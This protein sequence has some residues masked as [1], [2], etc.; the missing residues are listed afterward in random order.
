MSDDCY[1]YDA[2]CVVESSSGRETI[3]RPHVVSDGDDVLQSN[4]H[5]PLLIIFDHA[6]ISARIISEDSVAVGMLPRS[7]VVVIV[8]PNAVGMGTQEARMARALELLRSPPRASDSREHLIQNLHA[9]SLDL[10]SVF[11]RA[12]A[13]KKNMQKKDEDEEEEDTIIL[14]DDIRAGMPGHHAPPPFSP[15]RIRYTLVREGDLLHLVYATLSR[16]QLTPSYSNL[17][18]IIDEA[19]VGPLLNPDL[20][21]PPTV[22]TDE[23][24]E[25]LIQPFSGGGHAKEHAIEINEEEEDEDEDEDEEV[26]EVKADKPQ[27]VAAARRQRKRASHAQRV[28]SPLLVSDGTRVTEMELST[29]DETGFFYESVLDWH[30][31]R[32]FARQNEPEFHRRNREVYVCGT[33]LAAVLMT[34]VANHPNYTADQVIAHRFSDKADMNLKDYYTTKDPATGKLKSLLLDRNFLFFPVNHRNRHWVLY[35]AWRPFS[36]E[37]GLFFIFDSM[38]SCV[39]TEEHDHIL[40]LIKLFLMFVERE[41]SPPGALLYAGHCKVRQTFKAPQQPMRSNACG[42]YVAEV[43]GCFLT[44]PEQREADVNR[45]L[46]GVMPFAAHF[47]EITYGTWPAYRARIHADLAAEVKLKKVN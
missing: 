26:K 1:Y 7:A 41:Y 21:P 23:D 40:K 28:L 11:H 42:F 20:E 8:A 34:P 46:R 27:M 38:D 29:F 43:I 45:M 2:R 47:G 24:F 16:A 13:A 12:L 17:D 22:C 18:R 9:Y 44:S 36:P 35:L 31:E 32:K 14:V 15:A 30:I 6:P 37:G 10:A 33:G 4:V 39:A 25:A 19:G 3:F 5:P